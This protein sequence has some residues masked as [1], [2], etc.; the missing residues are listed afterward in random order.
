MEPFRQMQKLIVGEIPQPQYL[1]HEPLAEQMEE[2][3]RQ[4]EFSA[5]IAAIVKRYEQA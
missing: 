3:S 4:K 1:W 2:A 5:T